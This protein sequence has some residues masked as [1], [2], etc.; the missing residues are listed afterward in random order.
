MQSK[1]Y[2]IYINL[3][4]DYASASLFSLNFDG[5]RW[6]LVNSRFVMQFMLKYAVGYVIDF[7]SFLFMLAQLLG[8]RTLQTG[9]C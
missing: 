7:L 3:K 4:S 8:D 6:I 2:D 1:D 9:R 5:E